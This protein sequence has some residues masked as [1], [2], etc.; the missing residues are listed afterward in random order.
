MDVAPAVDDVHG[1]APEDVLAGKTY[2]SLRSDG[3]GLQVGTG[4]FFIGPPAPVGET[5]QVT[6]YNASGTAIACAGTGQDGDLRPGVQWPAPR[7]TDN[8]NGTVTDN[9]TGLIW[10]KNANCFGA[11][12]WTTALSDANGLASGSCGLV[13]GSSAGDWRLPSIFELQTLLDY[14]YYAPVLSNAAGTGQWTEG[15][16]FSGVEMPSWSS[17]TD[18]YTP[19]SALYLAFGNGA[20]GQTNKTSTDYFVWPVRG[21]Q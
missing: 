10:L 3:W 20:V 15:D 12:N 2:W 1:A 7:F 21:G 18:V 14:E 11:R 17:T 4:S 19:S 16:A 9:L 6:C 8:G 13:D 5:G